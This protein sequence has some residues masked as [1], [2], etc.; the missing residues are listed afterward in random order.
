MK[1][2]QM[3]IWERF[4]KGLLVMTGILFIATGSGYLFRYLGFSEENIIIVYILG[5]LIIAIITVNR[6]WSVCYSLLSVL[7]FNF[8]FTE[9]RFT[10]S[11]YDYGYPVTFVTVFIAAMIVSN[12]TIQIRKQ[13]YRAEQMALRTRILLETNQ[14]LQKAKNADEMIEE[15]CMEMFM[16]Q[17]SADTLKNADL[18]GT[19]LGELNQDQLA[20]INNLDWNQLGINI[21][22]ILNIIGEIPK[23]VQ[24][25]EIE[26]AALPEFLKNRLLENNNST[27]YQELGVKSFPE[28]AAS[29]I[30]RMILKVVAFLVTFIL[31][32]IL[33][34]ALMAAV[35]LIGEL[36]ILG[37]FNHLGGAVVGAAAALVI[38][39]LLFLIITLLYNN[40]IGQSCFEMIEKSSILTFLY[41][42]NILITKLLSF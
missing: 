37:F 15:K 24:I 29:Y 8:L 42:N 21:Q 18:S 40:A 25:Q 33:V 3:K 20:D 11:S 31:V 27:I 32:W 10:F 36:P 7:L 9:P 23:E 2:E 30:A 13:G 4:L 26:N 35:D 38:V 16:P 41:D 22:D 28:Y 39:W 5:V 17:I 14:M 12:L 6:G 34:R 19:S 1:Q